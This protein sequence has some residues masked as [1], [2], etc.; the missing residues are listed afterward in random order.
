[1]ETTALQ[2]LC[3]GCMNYLDQRDGPCP[4]CGGRLSM[5]RFRRSGGR[6]VE[7]LAVCDC[8]YSIVVIRSIPGRNRFVRIS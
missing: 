4:V 2:H 5:G 8:G 6:N 7:I 1:M 3:L